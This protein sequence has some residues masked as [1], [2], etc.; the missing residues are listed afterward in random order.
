MQ[1]GHF[2]SNTRIRVGRENL[3]RVNPRRLV[4]DGWALPSAALIEVFR[5]A[6]DVAVQQLDLLI[7][8]SHSRSRTMLLS[9]LPQ[10]SLQDSGHDGGPMT[11]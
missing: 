9:V 7:G 10:P 4:D 2:G 5:A 11:W 6:L 8:D 3:A 1:A